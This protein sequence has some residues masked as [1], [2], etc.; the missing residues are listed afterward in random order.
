MRFKNKEIADAHLAF[1]VTQADLQAV[2]RNN[3]SQEEA[4]RKLDALKARAR[5]RFKELCLTHHPDRTDDA[6]KIEH[7]KRV[8]IV[9]SGFMDLRVKFHGR[10]QAY[11]QPFRVFVMN[12]S[13]TGG[14]ATTTNSGTDGWLSWEP[15]R[16]TKV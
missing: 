2:L 10:P 13:G 11:A 3:G 7:F 12:F 1:G 6:E 4:D 14:S 5:K 9:Y 16:V 8:S 15:F